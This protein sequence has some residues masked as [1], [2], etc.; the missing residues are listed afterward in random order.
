MLTKCKYYENG[1]QCTKKAVNW[2]YCDMHYDIVF[3]KN[4][5]PSSDAIKWVSQEIKKLF[6]LANKTKKDKKGGGAYYRGG[7][8]I[9]LHV[10][11]YNGC[12]HVKVGDD[13]YRFIYQNKFQQNKWDAGIKA[14]GEKDEKTKGVIFAAMAIELCDAKL[15]YSDL[16]LQKQLEKLA[17]DKYKK[18]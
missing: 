16:E 7:D 2:D 5:Q 17:L 4:N 18:K 1:I 12:V 6:P 11:C 9:G 13:A 8:T 15:F 3:P 10:H 14:V